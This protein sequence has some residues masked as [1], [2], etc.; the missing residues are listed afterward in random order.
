MCTWCTLDTTQSEKKSSK[1][2]KIIKWLGYKGLLSI[3]FTIT[4]SAT[5]TLCSKLLSWHYLHSRTVKTETISDL[6]RIVFSWK[7]Q[8]LTFSRASHL[9]HGQEIAVALNFYQP[10]IG[11][12]IIKPSQFAELGQI[13]PFLHIAVLIL[14]HIVCSLPSVHRDTASLAKNRVKTAQ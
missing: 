7:N 1:K 14:W 8:N 2:N 12:Q 3:G 6:S 5:D 10:M 9:L 13:P 11:P 4:M